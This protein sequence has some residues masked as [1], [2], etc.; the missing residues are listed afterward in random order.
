MSIRLNRKKLLCISFF[1][2][3]VLPACFSWFSVDD[4]QWRGLSLMEMPL[5][6]S[7]CL[8]VFALLF[9][10]VRYMLPMGILSHLLLILF[11][12]A[13]FLKFPIGAGISSVQDLSL[14]L[15]ATCPMFWVSTALHLFHLALFT[16][17]E[18]AMQ[19][20]SKHFPTGSNGAA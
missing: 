3:C 18:I 2:C 14:S 12:V 4:T 10:H 11:S 7:T 20:L 19:K 16:T 6:I 8:F 9:E 17:T 15:D 5:L 1:L 13:C